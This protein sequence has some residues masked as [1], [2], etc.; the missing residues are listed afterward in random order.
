MAGV[1]VM[2]RR[3]LAVMGTAA[4]VLL[5]GMALSG[6]I[7]R[8]APNQT[9]TMETLPPDPE[10]VKSARNIA[11]EIKAKGEHLRRLQDQIRALGRKGE[12]VRAAE[13]ADTALRA[14]ESFGFRALRAEAWWHA[15]HPERA[16][17]DF[18]QM[19]GSSNP[20]ATADLLA[21]RGD[22]PAY[23][24][25]CA[26]MLKAVPP[27]TVSPFAANNT[28]WACLLLP[29]GMPDYAEPV[30]LARTAVA[31]ARPGEDWLYR[32]TLGVA[33]Y[34]A[35]QDAEAIQQLLQAEKEQSTPFNWPF[36]ALAYHR[37]GNETEARKWYGRLKTTIT[38]TFATRLAQDNRPE[39]L[40]FLH[41]AQQTF[42]A[43]YQR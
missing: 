21:L 1:D 2:G 12:W 19:L 42:E 15:G 6:L 29:D 8:F 28:A 3:R 4:S 33:L 14:E 35:N 41:E 16:L 38:G 30:Q 24:A 31:D 7:Q 36:L 39:L 34:R 5:G 25:H 37:T 32:N 26:G 11:R 43:R 40:L 23:Q 10:T 17:P 20:V 9:P 18:E 27:E 22:R 13:A